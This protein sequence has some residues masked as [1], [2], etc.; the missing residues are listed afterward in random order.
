ME[1]VHD[2]NDLEQL[3]QFAMNLI[4]W[5]RSYRISGI[6]YSPC[7]KITQSIC[8]ENVNERSRNPKKYSMDFNYKC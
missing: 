3:A 7:I 8:R 6:Q 5:N 1:M 2:F 4:D